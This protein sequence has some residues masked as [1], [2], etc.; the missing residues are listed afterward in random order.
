MTKK[1]TKN[2]KVNSKVNESEP[3][4]KFL[5]KLV[6]VV[7]IATLWLKFSQP[8]DWLGVTF[9]AIPIGVFIGLL[10]I[11]IFEHFQTDR[12][13][14]FA[15]IVIVGILSYFVPAGIVI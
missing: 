6:V 10:L 5:L 1:Q 4:S 3:D 8:H 12:K 9:T 11:H 7:L 15:V 14:W 2:R 13:I